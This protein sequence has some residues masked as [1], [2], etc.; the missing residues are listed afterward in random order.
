MTGHVLHD[1]VSLASDVHKHNTRFATSQNLYSTSSRTNYRLARFRV[2]A[3]QTWET[4]PTVVNCLPYNVFKKKYK[5]FL[6]DS[7][8]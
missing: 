5:L 7:Q 2:V 6:L 1:L 3:S 4:I 8:T